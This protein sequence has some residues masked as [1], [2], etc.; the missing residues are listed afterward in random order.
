MSERACHECDW[1]LTP[2][3][4]GIGYCCEPRACYISPKTQRLMPTLAVVVRE[5]P[6]WCGPE[7][8]WYRAIPKEQYAVPVRGLSDKPQ[9]VI[10]PQ[11]TPPRKKHKQE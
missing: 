10:A 2:H 4:D 6:E 8:K 11:F 9:R 5:D 1:F 3:N 7:G